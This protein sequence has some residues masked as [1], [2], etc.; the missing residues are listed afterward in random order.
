MKTFYHFNKG[1]EIDDWTINKW[2]RECIAKIKEGNHHWYMASGDT[3]VIALNHPTEIQ[4]TVANS[5]GKSTIS[6]STSPGQEDPLE[7]KEY[8]RPV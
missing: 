3:A 6:F 4:V 8:V 1:V 7:F 2:I 5:A